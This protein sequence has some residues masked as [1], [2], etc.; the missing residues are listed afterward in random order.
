MLCRVILKL[1]LNW[2]E[3]CS[4]NSTTH[5]LSFLIFC[6]RL[7]SFTT[8]NYTIWTTRETSTGEALEEARITT[9]DKVAAAGTKEEVA[10][11]TV[12]AVEAATVVAVEDLNMEEVEVDGTKAVAEVATEVV[13]AMV[14]AVASIRKEISKKKEAMA[15]VVA[16][17]VEA[18]AAM[19]EVAEEATVEETVVVDIPIL[20]MV[21]ML[22][23]VALLHAELLIHKALIIMVVQMQ[24]A[25]LTLEI[26]QHLK[27]AI[28]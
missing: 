7:Y 13:V 24:E 4:L 17:A 8:Y 14:E 23:L 11:A 19:V 15:A 1:T 12:A 18:E 20:I 25:I 21:E 5:F 9:E 28:P 2:I 26:S 6:I 22:M 10:V 3:V 27:T 16:M